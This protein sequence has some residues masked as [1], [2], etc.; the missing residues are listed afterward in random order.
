MTRK[1]KYLDIFIKEAE[2]HLSGLQKGLISLE[3]EPVNAALIHELMRNAHTLKGSA[4]ML[5]I[6]DISAVA[7]RMEDLLKEVEEGNQAVDAKVIDRLLKGTD[8]ITRLMHALAADQ[9][10]PLD[11]VKFLAAFDGEQFPDEQSSSTEQGGKDEG[12]FGDTVRAK[13]K[14]LD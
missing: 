11:V 10:T 14:T 4:K 6:E 13:V 12:A 2:E 8:V 1:V 7:H 9:E 5:G 3:K